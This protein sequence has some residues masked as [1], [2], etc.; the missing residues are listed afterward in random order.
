MRENNSGRVAFEDSIYRFRMLGCF[1]LH[2]DG[3]ALLREYLDKK[4]DY[5]I[6]LFLGFRFGIRRIEIL[7]YLF[8]KVCLAELRLKQNNSN[9]K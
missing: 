2:M 4:R 8:L 6:N 1:I 3:E 7:S 5:I 9:K